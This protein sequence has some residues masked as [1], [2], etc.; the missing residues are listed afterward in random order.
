MDAA[1][2]EAA[3][4]AMAWKQD[5]V[6][7]EHLF[8]GILKTDTPL[9][10]G[11]QVLSQL[12]VDPRAVLKTIAEIAGMPAGR[13]IPSRL[14]LTAR[15]VRLLNMAE[16]IRRRRMA[17][18]VD[19]GHVMEAILTE[20]ENVPFHAVGIELK[21]LPDGTGPGT[22]WQK[23]FVRKLSW[24]RGEGWTFPLEAREALLQALPATLTPWDRRQG[25]QEFCIKRW[26]WQVKGVIHES[27]DQFLVW[28]PMRMDRVWQEQWFEPFYRRATLAL[29]NVPGARPCAPSMIQ[30]IWPD[31]EEKLAGDLNRS[32]FT[33]APAPGRLRWMTPADHGFC[34]ALHASLEETDQVPR[35]F[36]DTFQTWLQNTDVCRYVL[37]VDGQF[38]GCCGL[39]LMLTESSAQGKEDSAPVRDRAQFSFG[40]VQPSRQR[41]GF[42]RLQIAARLVIA[43]RL[44]CKT[45]QVSGTAFSIDWLE[46]MGFRCWHIDRSV[47]HAPGFVASVRLTDEDAAFL[48]S[49]LGWE[50]L[51]HLMPEDASDSSPRSD[52]N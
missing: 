32:L 47:P 46:R 10:P 45:A 38:A 39:N 31:T 16:T 25:T 1:L 2:Q 3:A 7:A 51:D 28:F 6:G 18:E 21:S 22:E 43:H 48:E 49:W 11:C 37:E 33:L 24:N 17:P 5:Y 42:G 52:E 44:G 27:P 26:W 12:D 40:L 36:A 34:T 9:G 4:Q 8:C 29:R 50:T 19:A 13:P 14:P 30:N 23:E 41:M 20:G 35:G 15:S